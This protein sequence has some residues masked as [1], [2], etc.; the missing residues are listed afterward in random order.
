M[1][2][3]NNNTGSEV[4]GDE[5]NLA[6]EVPAET[7]FTPL[8]D[9]DFTPA[10]GPALASEKAKTSQRIHYEAQVE[11]IK[12]QIGSLESARVQLGLSAR[13]MCQLLLVDPSAW[14]RWKKEGDAPPHI[15]RALQWYL[16]LQEKIP[17][18][19]AQYFIGKDPEVLQ[20]TTLK[21]VQLIEQDLLQNN[22]ILE[23]K[24][25]AAEDKI[26]ALETAIKVNRMTT[27]MVG[28]ATII[29]A[30]AFYRLLKG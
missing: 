25:Q 23:Q 28:L 8:S 17:G 24:N 30:F 16:T 9:L 6:K 1:D 14:T 5:K 11:V 13:K 4:E 7:L 2:I 10:D 29:M 19:T 26:K 27:I 21:R 12:R 3:V 15:W 18:L 22:I 20:A